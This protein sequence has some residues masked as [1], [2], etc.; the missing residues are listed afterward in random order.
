[1]SKRIERTLKRAFARFVALFL[2]RR[3]IT[4]GEFNDM[5]ISR[6]LVVRQHNQMGDMLLAAAAFRG[7]RRRFPEAR[8]SLVAAPINAAVAA[9]NPYVDEVLTYAK[10]RNRGNPLALAAFVA[11]LRRRRFD[12]V[13]VLNT[14]SFSIT[15]MLLAASS[16]AR[17][18][19]GSTSEPFGHDLSARFYHLELPLPRPEELALMHESRHNLYPLAT[20]GVREDDL[21]S[22]VV[23]TAGE[24]ADAGRFIAA[25]VG[26]GSPFVVIH[27]GAG[28][29][30]NVWPP[31]RFAEVASALRE[32]HGAGVIAVR[33]PVDGSA[34]DAFLRACRIRPAVVSSPGIGF[35]ASLM[36]RASCTVC[37]DTGVMHVAGAAGAR[38]VAVF[39]PTDPRRWKPVNET[40]VA[41]R[42]DDGRVESVA[43]E[44]VL[45]AIERL[46]TV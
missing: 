10:R 22:V 9:R 33:G 8:I 28:K 16:G 43:V 34:A 23:P 44:A 3:R 4:P 1:V 40:V 7:L 17:V 38:C 19:L 21:R 46:L 42:A 20:I 2:D 36:K 13:I 41:V 11:E 31:A 12:A 39:G 35:L 37:N 27:P 18:R 26:R 15:S 25:A 30:G 32:R 29:Q 14:V 24:E 45:A 5:K 6:L